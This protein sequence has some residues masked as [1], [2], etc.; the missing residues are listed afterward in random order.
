MG[1]SKGGMVL[2]NPCGFVVPKTPG[3]SFNKPP[4]LLLS[5]F[6]TS[7]SLL[8]VLQRAYEQIRL[9]HVQNQSQGLQFRLARLGRSEET[10]GVRCRRGPST[11]KQLEDGLFR[12]KEGFIMTCLLKTRPV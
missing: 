12:S 5:L 1:G 8:L 2:R 3:S 11:P 7:R 9:P 4:S 6:S 10:P